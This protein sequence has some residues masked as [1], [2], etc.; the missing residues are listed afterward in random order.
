[1]EGKRGPS[2]FSSAYKNSFM[3]PV[4]LSSVPK[5]ANIEKERG[6][7]AFE[8]NI[9]HFYCNH[10]KKYYSFKNTELKFS[11]VQWE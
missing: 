8:V 11:N 3:S 1:M 10:L 4:K 6:G 9:L 7:F 5:S 2:M